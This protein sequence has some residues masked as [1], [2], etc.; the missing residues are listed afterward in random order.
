[1]FHVDPLLQ[2]D[3]LQVAGEQCNIAFAKL[4]AKRTHLSQKNKDIKHLS[5]IGAQIGEDI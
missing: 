4:F 3:L 2:D 1:M 5:S